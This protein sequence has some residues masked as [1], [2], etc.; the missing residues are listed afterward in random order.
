MKSSKNT[1]ASIALGLGALVFA[2]FLVLSDPQQGGQVVQQIQQT[3]SNWAPKPAATPT[4]LSPES[5]MDA[6]MPTSPQVT[7]APGGNVRPDQSLSS[8]ESYLDS[9]WKTPQAAGQ[10]NQGMPNQFAQQQGMQSRGG[11]ARMLMS[12]SGFGG[13]FGRPGIRRSGFQRQG[14]QQQ[15][16]QQQSF[17]QQGFQQQG[18][19]QPGGQRPG[20]SQFFGQQPQPN[21]N[22]N[23]QANGQRSAEESVRYELGVARSEAAQ[24]YSCL[25]RTRGAEDSSQKR[26][27][28]A[29]ARSHAS[30]ANSA[31]SRALSRGG[32]VPEV[33]GL[34]GDVR[35]TAARAQ[36]Y[37]DQASSAASGW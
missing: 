7:P 3:T 25:D 31:A 13:G 26:S 22:M 4:A 20:L 37:A 11:G 17:Q 32:S 12:Q 1:M 10:A 29:E 28:A 14:F 24:A 9:A 8:A 33:Q 36:D 27:A 5:R 35:A 18:F 21:P 15:G 19:Q 16:F 23:Q 34:I 30:Q 6:G 2:F